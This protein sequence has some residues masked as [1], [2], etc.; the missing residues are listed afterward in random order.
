MILILHYL[1]D[2]ELWELWYIPFLRVM[3][4]LY[5]HPYTGFRPWR[6]SESVANLPILGF[7]VLGLGVLLK[8][9][10]KGSIKGSSNG[11]YEGLGCRWEPSSLKSLPVRYFLFKITLD[12]K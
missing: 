8:A 5:H 10:Y 9:I 7:R 11:M 4:D 6:F 3:Q 1:K 2:P 12:R